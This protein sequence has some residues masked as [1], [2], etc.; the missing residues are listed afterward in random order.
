M[1]THPE[2]IEGRSVLNVQKLKFIK[3]KLKTLYLFLFFLFLAFGFNPLI[4]YFSLPRLGLHFQM[5]CILLIFFGFVFAF[6]D[7]MEDLK[8]REPKRTI[9]GWITYFAILILTI[10]VLIFYLYKFEKLIL[11]HP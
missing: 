6:W 11:S 4:E 3:N 2:R 1:P 8:A 9:K 10:S 5:M 7:S